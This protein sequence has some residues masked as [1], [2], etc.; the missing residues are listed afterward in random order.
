MTHAEDLCSLHCLLRD[1]VIAILLVT[2]QP[3]VQYQVFLQGWEKLSSVTANGMLEN[4]LERHIMQTLHLSRK[5]KGC[6]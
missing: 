2:I 1:D 5:N 4:F 6:K 3:C